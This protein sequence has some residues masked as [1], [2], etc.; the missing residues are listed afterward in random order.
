M[1][2]A[3][4]SRAERAVDREESKARTKALAALRAWEPLLAAKRAL[5]PDDVLE[6]LSGSVS[7]LLAVCEPSEHPDT[8]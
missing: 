4:K 3:K 8:P 1:E 7:E 6:V 5:R 2:E